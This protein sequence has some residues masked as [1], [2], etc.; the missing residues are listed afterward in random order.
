MFGRSKKAPI[1]LGAFSYILLLVWAVNRAWVQHQTSV[2]Q[3]LTQAR[4]LNDSTQAVL[5]RTKF[6]RDSLRAL[7]KAAKELNGQ[8]IAAVRILVARR[9]TLIVHGSTFTKVF[10][11]GTRTA[12]FRDSLSWAQV[13]GTITAPPYPGALGVNYKLTR[14]AF[15]PSVGFVKSGNAYVAVVTW[16]GEKFEI[17]TPYFDP[18]VVEPRLAPYVRVAWS[19]LGAGLAGAGMQFR[20]G[21]FRPYVEVQGMATLKE[22]TPI[23]WL[24]TTRRF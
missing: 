15:S 10:T 17:S 19:P 5:A 1:R 22:F 16:Q 12:S 3:E 11:D 8:L 24:G 21:N 14:P 6:E 4:H 13:E 9:D 20:V 23:V 7:H 2:A 18:P